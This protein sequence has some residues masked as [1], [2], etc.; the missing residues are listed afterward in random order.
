MTSSLLD[1]IEAERHEFLL[2]K[3][4]LVNARKGSHAWTGANNW[5]ARGYFVRALRATC[6]NCGTQHDSLMGVF[7]R[8]TNGRGDLRETALNGKGLPC[9][10]FNVAP[11]PREYHPVNI[12]MCLDCIP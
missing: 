9:T 11:L 5:T 6:K 12:P 2:E 1:E 10:P 8:E 4:N 7:L 3:G